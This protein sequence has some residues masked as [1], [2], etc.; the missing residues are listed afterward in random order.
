MSFRILIILSF[1]AANTLFAQGTFF[2]SPDSLLKKRIIPVS[3]GAGT[4]WA[5]SMVGLSQVWYKDYGKS[6]FHTFNDGA[7]WLQMDKAGHIYT[8]YQIS[9]FTGDLFNGKEKVKVFA[10]LKGTV[11]HSQD[12]KTN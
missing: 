7:N 1:F 9:Q 4:C 3:I 2:D 5:G 12:L 6:S 11:N 10:R 8:N